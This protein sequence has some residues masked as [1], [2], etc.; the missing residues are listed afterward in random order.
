MRSP[1]SFIDRTPLGGAKLPA[2]LLGAEFLARHPIN[3]TFEIKS[4]IIGS[5]KMAWAASR[6]AFFLLHSYSFGQGE[7]LSR[8]KRINLK[9]SYK[10]AFSPDG[11]LLA[12]IGRDVVSWDFPRGEKRFRVHP[13]SHPSHVAFSRSGDRLA[14]KNTAGRIVILDPATGQ[15]AVDFGNKRDGEGCGPVFSPCDRYLV[16]GTWGGRLLVRDA[17]S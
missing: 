5:T 13:L 17:G 12:V 8:R 10:V 11:Q 1:K 16:D 4:K 15:V 3:R 9:V 7:R 6:E 2:T 14:V